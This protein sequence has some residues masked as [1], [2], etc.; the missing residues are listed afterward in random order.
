MADKHVNKV[1]LGDEVLIDL[2]GDTVDAEHILIG[3]TAHHRS[4]QIIEGTMP[5]NGAVKGEISDKDVPYI[6]PSGY[7]DG[8]GEVG[9]AQSEL[10]KLVPENIRMGVELLG[11]TGQHI[12]DLNYVHEQTVAASVWTVVHNLDKYPAVTVVDSANTVIL[13][14]IKYLDLNSLQIMFTSEFTGRAYCN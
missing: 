3:K 1:E 11:V 4:G 6:V 14:D 12:G 7:H 2:T 13:G 9:I 8:A 10:E 5:D